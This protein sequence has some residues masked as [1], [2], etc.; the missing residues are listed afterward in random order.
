MTLKDIFLYFSNNNNKNELKHIKNNNTI[1]F[2]SFI[3]K[4]NK[5]IDF[6]LNSPFIT[7]LKKYLE[8]DFFKEDIECIKINKGE[9]Y[10]KLY[11]LLGK[12]LIEH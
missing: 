6:I 1:K 10:A 8:S 5:E 11:E 2:L 3:E 9:D 4:K 7:I 12:R